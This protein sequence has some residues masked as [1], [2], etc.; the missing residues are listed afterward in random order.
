MHI[1]SLGY[2]D[3]PSSDMQQAASS[4]YRSLSFLIPCPICREHY[5]NHLKST[6][7]ATES[8]KALVEWVWIIHNKVNVDIG[9]LEVSFDAFMNHMESLSQESSISIHMITGLCTGIAL[10]AFVYFMIL[11]K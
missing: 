1:I 3:D 9:K 8:K 2:P 10:S 7:P 5:T 4:F 6:P 11:R